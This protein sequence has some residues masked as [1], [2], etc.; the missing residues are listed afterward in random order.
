[1]ADG[2]AISLEEFKARLPLIEI[3]ARHVRLTRRGREHLGLCPFHQEKTPS[4]TVSEA[5]GFYHCFGCGQ[6]GNAIDFVMALE[7]L[8]F[9]QAIARLR[10]AD[11]P[12][13][14]APR[15]QRRAAGRSHALRGQRGG[16]ALAGR[17]VWRARRAPRPR[18]IWTKRGARPRDHPALR[19][20]LRALRPHRAEARAPGRGLRRA[21]RDRGG[22]PGP[23]RGRRPELRPLPP[24]GDVPDP[25]P[26]RPD[27]R[28]RRP[29][30]RRGAS[31]VPEYARHAAV[32]Q[33]RAAVRP[34]ARKGSGR[35]SA[36]R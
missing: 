2:G 17:R 22:P 35:A 4:F 33:G 20:R 11:R 14:A 15:R 13:G 8:D 28:L 21:D 25:R 10:R 3:V 9:G 27:R 31:Q 32:P 24:P 12:A 7:G 29:G 1:M 16:G 36:A 19:A 23:A 6:H 30:A 5:K 34:G 26:A 18:P